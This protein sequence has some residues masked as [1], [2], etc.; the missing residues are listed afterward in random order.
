MRLNPSLFTISCT[1]R[2]SVSNDILVVVV[3]FIEMFLHYF[4]WRMVLHGRE[5]PRLL[6]YGLGV[7]GLM[8][9]FTAWLIDRSNQGIAIML[10][11][12]LCAGGL[13]VGLL[14]LLDWVINQVWSKR[15]SEQRERLLQEQLDGKGKSA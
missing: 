11:V 6:A 14:Y 13:A 3:V 8:G 5:L 1:W 15:E 9:P 7:L 2:L 12:V 4:P 10:W